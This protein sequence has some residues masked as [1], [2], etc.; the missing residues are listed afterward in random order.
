M[1]GRYAPGCAMGASRGAARYRARMADFALPRTDEP[2]DFR[3]QAATYGRWRRD[4]SPALY[5]EMAA[6]SG[7]AAGRLALDV[8]C[9]TGFVTAS[10]G[11][12]GWNAV[13]VDFSRPMLA[14]ARAASGGALRLVRAR[15]EMLPMRDGEA[16][17]VTCGTS[18][19]WLAPLPALAEFH[20]VLAPG[21]WVALFWRYAAQGEP[22][23]RLVADVLA[24]VGVPMSSL[25][26]EFRVHPVD[27]FAGSGF[28]NVTPLVLHPVLAFT[29]EEFHG[30]MSTIEWIRR[31]A[32]AAHAD[33]L[34]R[35]RDE[36]AAHHPDGFEERNEEYLFL[37]RRAG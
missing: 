27:P 34:A 32:G 11:Q 12:R 14:E 17:L 21:G 2:F 18:F 26:E 6:R 36:L 13:G 16:A 24:R 29:A 7:P 9:G 3:H 10:L 28:E 37:A 8:G 19:H 5:D 1:A 33:F 31:F 15:G 30:Y 23:S 20:R 35:L 4:Y 25:V 22:S